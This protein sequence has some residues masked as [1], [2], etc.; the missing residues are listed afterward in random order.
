M[1]MVTSGKSL[2]F[3]SFKSLI[4]KPPNGFKLSFLPKSGKLD[5]F[6]RSGKL[7]LPTSRPA[8]T[9]S[10]RGQD[11]S[12]ILSMPS[13]HVARMN[14]FFEIPHPKPTQVGQ[15]LSKDTATL[16][17]VRLTQI[18]RARDKA[19]PS[20]PQNALSRWKEKHL[21][22]DEQGIPR[23][24]G[25]PRTDA[26]FSDLFPNPFK[27]V[28]ARS[29]GFNSDH[30]V[31]V[32][33]RRSRL[34]SDENTLLLPETKKGKSLASNNTLLRRL[35]SLMS[36]PPTHVPPH[37]L[38]LKQ[39][40]QQVGPPPPLKPHELKLKQLERQ[41]GPP[42]PLKPHELKLKQLERQVGPPPPLP[43][44]EK[45]LS[46]S[47]T[48]LSEASFKTANRGA[49]SAFS[50]SAPRKLETTYALDELD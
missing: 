28:P 5:T 25:V 2:I 22:K 29:T 34:V 38:K 10:A 41:V 40:A 35:R 6:N 24:F 42:P 36:S 11:L 7:T 26:K 32:Q 48:L 31:I 45:P 14:N 49:S 1:S 50:E 44:K 30:F 20:L 47:S 39:L 21:T 17:N 15:D 13:A 43:P 12:E 16:N 33:P 18:P 46:F 9:S 27:P 23:W 19:L 8:T 4:P 3:S 37:K